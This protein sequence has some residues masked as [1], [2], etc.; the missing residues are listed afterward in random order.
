MS[1][2]RFPL[3]FDLTGREIRMVGGG[4][5]AER[6]VRVLLPF[7]PEI[8]LISP[9]LTDA[10][11]ELAGDGKIAWQART[12]REGDLEGADLV[13]AATDDPACD[14]AVREECRERGIPVNLASDQVACDFFFPAIVRRDPL[15]IGVTA[16]GRDHTLTRGTAAALREQ[17]RTIR[18]GTR[19]S[20]LAMLQSEQAAEHLRKVLPCA[21]IQLVPMKTTGDKILDRRLDQIGGKGLFVKELDQALRDGRSDISV[22][23]LKDLPMEIPEDLPI[24][25]YSRREDPRDVL[26]LPKGVSE[27]DPGKPVGTSS[28]R[29]M[30]QFECLHPEATFRNVRGNV[31]TRL[32][33][34]DSG[35]YGALILA[36]AGLKRLGLEDRISYYFPIGE[37]IPAAG[38]GILAVQGRAGERIPALETFFDP[39][40]EAEAAAERS[41]VA[42]L[43]GGC[44]SPIAANAKA[45]WG[46]ITIRGLFYKEETGELS[47]GE[48]SG[49]VGE[50]AGLGRALA[51]LLREG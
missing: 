38:Q 33:K 15:V 19:E 10:L 36:A 45:E 12:Y 49:P 32:A 34:L 37:M 11:G 8:T 6:R 48:M 40:S 27:W 30:L 43:G 46:T 22:H 24:L 14:R 41:F 51:D 28:R 26:V 29:R 21:D 35:E 7:G 16:S 23:S 47:T 1:D 18:I 20:R 2:L 44:S 42:A 5:V 50:A 31:L 17:F 39:D 4:A 13:F 9:T 3:Y 25:G